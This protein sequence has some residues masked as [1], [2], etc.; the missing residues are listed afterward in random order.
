MLWGPTTLHFIGRF[1]MVMDLVS[2]Y[3]LEEPEE[4]IVLEGHTRLEKLAHVVSKLQDSDKDVW[5]LVT[6]DLGDG[7]STLSMQLM[8]LISK[9]NQMKWSLRGNVLFNPDFKEINNKIY[10]VPHKTTLQLDEAANLLHARNWNSTDQINFTI[11]SD[12][13]RYRKLCMIANIRMMK[14]V[15]ILFRNGR[16]FYWIDIL[17]KGIAGIFARD[18]SYSLRSKGDAFN[19]DILLDKI[20]DLP[21]NDIASRMDAY[22]SM[23]N[24]R[25]FLYFKPLGEK[26]QNA[27]NK[28]KEGSDIQQYQKSKD[29]DIPKEERERM[30]NNLILTL[31]ESGHSIKEIAEK[32][33]IG[34]SDKLITENKIKRLILKA[35]RV[36]VPKDEKREE[37]AK[38][39]PEKLKKE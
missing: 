1:K 16:F 18:A 23:S 11:T 33:N 38:I 4:K 27:Y 13:I 36:S 9:Y 24:F 35:R 3:P 28:L 5:I 39:E 20:Q 21:I 31:F 2:K 29:K 7:K 8:R 37:A 15:D 17:K 34:N 25:G 26:L 10:T 22:E 6:G 19:S 30:M 32:A 12:R 14:E